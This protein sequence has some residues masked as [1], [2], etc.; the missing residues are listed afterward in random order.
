MPSAD[1]T[2]SGNVAPINVVGTIRIANESAKRMIV[3]RTGAPLK[4]GVEPDVE[5][6]NR[7]E[8]DGV[9]SAATA[10][11]ASAIAN[12]RSGRPHAIGKSSRGQRCRGRG[13]S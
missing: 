1:F 7:V 10:T 4:V 2:T 9:H 8:K 11:S 6:F 5:K 13:P 3:T 12:A